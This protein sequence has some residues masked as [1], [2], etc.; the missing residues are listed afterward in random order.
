MDEER[1]EL[2]S[3]RLTDAVRE[4]VEKELK[5]RYW[6]LGVIT[7]VLTSGTVTLI[8]NAIL[9]DARLKLEI[10]QAVQEFSSD[11][12]NKASEAVEKLTE[13]TAKVQ[14]EF[15]KRATDAEAR[16]TGLADR[17]KSLADELSVSSENSLKAISDLQLQTDSLASILRDLINEPGVSP[18]KRIAL[19]T[20]VEKIQRSL[21]ASGERIKE[22]RSKVEALRKDFNSVMLGKWSIER[23]LNSRGRTR[24]G[25]LSIDRRTEDNTFS[26]TLTIAADGVTIIEEV[27]VT[28][29]EAVVQ[30]DTKVIKGPGWWAPDKFTLELNGDLLRGSVKDD[31]GITGEIVFRKIL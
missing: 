31:S 8:V 17:G 27:V 12:I 26:G 29:K 28:R 6:W 21:G 2:V 18:A 9:A 10:A 3:R 5:R 25:I 7:L 11:R 1:E 30:I 22:A 23:W 16:F 19:V 24:T 13:R 20:E 4:S 15:E 14:S